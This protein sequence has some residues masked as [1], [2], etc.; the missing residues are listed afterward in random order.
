MLLQ[1][2]V[3]A[4]PSNLL[5][6]NVA[7]RSTPRL[8]LFQSRVL[9]LAQVGANGEREYFEPCQDLL[10]MEALIES[11]GELVETTF[12]ARRRRLTANHCD[13]SVL[14]RDVPTNIRASTLQVHA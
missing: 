8:K 7:N 13:M 6:I 12:Q 5:Y 9:T 2:I 3:L 1:R 4:R 10:E 11:E 14:A